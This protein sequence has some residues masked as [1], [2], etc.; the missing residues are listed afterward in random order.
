MTQ[1]T[2]TPIEPGVIARLT[3]G[4]RY[5]LTGKAPEWFGPLDP[6]PP[7]AQD[8][9]TGRQ[10]DYP[11]GFNT[12]T[13]PRSGE[14][15]GFAE[16]R[17]LAD[18]YDLMRL[19]IE[20]RKD[21]ICG[22]KW[23]VQPK[24]EKAKPDAR[25]EAIG[26]FLKLP[27]REH[28]WSQWLRA[29]VEDL[30]VI[31]APTIYPRATK[32]GELYSLD[33]M[34]GATIKRVID[35]TGRTP[36][37]PDPA[38]QQILK[39]VPAVDYTRDQLIYRPRNVRTSRVYG[40]SP[41]EQVIMTVNIA[42]RRQ[43][44]QLQFYTEGN[45]PEALIGVPETWTTDQIRVFQEYWDSL[46]EGSTAKRRHAKFVPG[47]M[48]FQ[49][50]KE[51]A[52]KDAFD[53]WLVRIICYAFSVSPQPFMVMMN[54]ATAEVASA[55][56][57]KE[58]LIP[59]MQWVKELM[60]DVIARYLKAPDL[61]FQWVVEE[62]ADPLK[63]AQTHEIYVRS[64][65]ITPDEVRADLGREPL[66]DEQKQAIKD[67]KPQPAHQA[68]GGEPPAGPQDKPE[69]PAVK[70]DNHIHLSSPDVIVDVGATTVKMGDAGAVDVSREPVV[71]RGY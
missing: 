60:D 39:G 53:E 32:G 42:V 23:S 52:L 62:A 28:T 43:I 9:A 54:R 6:L 57:D 7:A 44:H 31:D 14:P 41:V 38:Y 3:A 48:R 66:T 35:A 4:V 49:P 5:A 71:K 29:L 18:G 45:I 55:S 36:I 64:G 16:M 13:T 22:L 67:A 68:P 47:S 37:A 34:D 65:V 20:T 1:G 19:V 70:V 24:N 63:K 15:V 69:P 30:L 40:Y 21:Q 10:F 56:A 51:A 58:G 11:T 8:K 33:L 46:L 50:T 17:A 25:C 59:L 61:H 2:A 26:A 27:D 12:R